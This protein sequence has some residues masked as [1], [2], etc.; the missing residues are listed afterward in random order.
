M[1]VKL[2]CSHCD[3]F[4]SYLNP[5]ATPPP[6][7][8]LCKKCKKRSNDLAQVLPQAKEYMIDQMNDVLAATQKKI[9]EVLV[10]IAQDKKPDVAKIVKEAFVK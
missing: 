8:N 7:P 10:A 1:A 3:D 2:C 4:I 6:E 5:N 9:E